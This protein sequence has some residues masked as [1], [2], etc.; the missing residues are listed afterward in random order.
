MAGIDGW[1]LR[2]LHVASRLRPNIPATLSPASAGDA[3]N[4]RVFHFWTMR[5]DKPALTFDEQ[6]ALL[7]QRGLH[8]PDT[9]RARHWLQRVS[10]Y[11]LSA[12]FLPFKHGELFR[13]GTDFDDVAGL[14]VFDRKLRLLVLDAIERIE[15]AMRTAVTYEVGHR[16]GAFGHTD[17]ANFSPH[18]EHT[19]FMI[20]LDTEERRARETFAAHFRSKYRSET[21]LP[22]WMATELLSFGTISQLYAS[23]SP[24]I[25]RAIAGEYG[26][27]DLHFASWLHTLSYT[28]NLC[29]HHKRLWSRQFAIRPKLPSRSRLWPHEI[30]DSG[31]VYA[32]L[33]IVRHM[34][35]D[36]RAQM[37][38]ARSAPRLDR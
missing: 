33:L 36:R 14:Y 8:V 22:V 32:V 13:A 12:Y 16:F 6:L 9:A 34:L 20:E 35:Q 3:H 11:R 7:Q 27:P 18:F 24:D 21:H 30:P 38:L 15:V 17:P 29:A 10:Y 25:K 19:K 37:P 23:L 28:R 5:Y 2:Q 31:K 1:K 26:V 4:W